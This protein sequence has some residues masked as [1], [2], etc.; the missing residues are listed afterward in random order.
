VTSGTVT[1][2]GDDTSSGTRFVTANGSEL[3]STA[4]IFAMYI[5]EGTVTLDGYTFRATALA[6]GS[7]SSP[8]T[9]FVTA[10]LSDKKGAGSTG[11]Y[12]WGKAFG[13]SVGE[14]TTMTVS[15]YNI[16]GADKN[17]SASVSS[18]IAGAKVYR[19][20]AAFRRQHDPRRTVRHLFRLRHGDELQCRRSMDDG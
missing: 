3:A 1:N 20:A 13:I 7:A 2:T 17:R 8:A 4:E 15:D 6:N 14:S 12:I 10:T 11:A 18:G 9:A 16:Y 19:R 5:E